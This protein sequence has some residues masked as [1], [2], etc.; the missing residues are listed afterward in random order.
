ML[1]DGNKHAVQINC[2]PILKWNS[3][4]VFLY[5]FSNELPLNNAYRLGA[6]R[7]GCLMCPMSREWYE[8]ILQQNYNDEITPYIDI[9]K[10]M[11]DKNYDNEDEWQ[12]YLREGGWKRRSSGKLLKKP[13]NKLTNITKNDTQ[14]IIIKRSNYPWDK[15]MRALGDIVKTGNDS[16]SVQYK[17]LVFD[18]NV[19]YENDSTVITFVEPVKTKSSTRFMYLFKNALVKAAY[20][21]NCKECMA[22]CPNGALTVTD[23]DIIIENCRHCERCLSVQKGCVVARSLISTGDTN[24]K[25]KSIDRYN[26]FGLKKEWVDLYFSDTTAFWNNEIMG[27]PMIKSF[28]RWGKEAGLIEDKNASVFNIGKLI[29][30]GTDSDVLWGYIYV[31]IAY[32]SAIVNWYLRNTEQDIKYTTSDL[33]IMI[34]EDYSATTVKNAFTSLKAT[35]KDSPIGSTLGQ[36]E[37]EMKGRTVVSLTRHS[38]KE[39][40][41]VVILYS[42]YMFAEHSDSLYSFTLSDL[43]ED[44]SE[45][46]GLSPQ[47]LF[48]IDREKLKPILQGLEHDHP[49]FISVDFN[50]GFMENI[51]LF[52][53]KTSADV[54]ELM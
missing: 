25:A 19:K 9:I 16:Y 47:L 20:C 26:R 29:S 18:F 51:R 31:N 53:E 52:R 40:D 27:E 35:M 34:G 30:L 4:E 46:E 11:I 2:N 45:R 49:D 32:N 44:F 50:K 5:I 3:G 22:E 24:M 17:E 14:S 48:G 54:V 33:T 43:T 42:L 38:W 23:D 28:E 39:P 13:D 21:R 8:Y 12:K 37:C 36:G 15:W 7:V 1:S 41:P 6:H 10:S